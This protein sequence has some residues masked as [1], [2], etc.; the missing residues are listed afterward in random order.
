M[1]FQSLRDEIVAHFEDPAVL[2]VATLQVAD[3]QS[4]VSGYSRLAAN[5]DSLHLHGAA[6]QAEL[7]RDFHS[8]SVRQA[9]AMQMAILRPL[10]DLEA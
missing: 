4:T 9:M 5:G 8:E 3:G 6:E 1:S 2:E 10:P 7:L